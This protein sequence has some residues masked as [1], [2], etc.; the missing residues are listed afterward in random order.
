[1]RLPVMRRPAGEGGSEPCKGGDSNDEL[2][3]VK[4]LKEMNSAEGSCKV[5]P[6]RMRDREYGIEEQLH[7]YFRAVEALQCSL[8]STTI[9]PRKLIRASIMQLRR[10]TRP[11][12]IDPG[13]M[14]F[15]VACIRRGVRCERRPSA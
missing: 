1:M 7:I 9:H 13:T 8:E 5:L 6:Y 2:H 12:I 11:V 14:R 3:C 15:N 4:I 10:V